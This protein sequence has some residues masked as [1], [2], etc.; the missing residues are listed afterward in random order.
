MITKQMIDILE[1]IKED[2]TITNYAMAEKL[3]ISRFRCR[4]VI[5]E[6]KLLGLI[7]SEQTTVNGRFRRNM[8][9]LREV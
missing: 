5:R 1:L 9:V 3:K 4:D 8:K 7:T 6:M 2:P